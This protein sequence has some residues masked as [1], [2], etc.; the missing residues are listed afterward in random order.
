[1]LFLR[2]PAE[3]AG[4]KMGKMVSGSHPFKYGT[5]ENHFRK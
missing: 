5:A 1:L 3:K 4:K 2:L